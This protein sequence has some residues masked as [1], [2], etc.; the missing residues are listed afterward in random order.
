MDNQPHIKKHSRKK[1]LA[2]VGL[3]FLVLLIAAGAAA[4][5]YKD[6]LFPGD[7]TNTVSTPSEQEPAAGI[8]VVEKARQQVSDGD[9]EGANKTLDEALKDSSDNKEK[10]NFYAVKATSNSSTNLPVAIEAA[11]QA[12]ELDKSSERYAYVAE[13]AER[14]SDTATAVE[15]Y[16]KALEAAQEDPSETGEIRGPEYFQNKLNTLGA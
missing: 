4:Y 3:L 16:T 8:D 7:D 2:V 9:I 11:K 12:A 5:Y 15:Y 10:V 14:Q 13:L 1:Q 6:K